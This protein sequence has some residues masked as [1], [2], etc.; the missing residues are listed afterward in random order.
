MNR[1]SSGAQDDQ[2]FKLMAVLAHPDDESLGFARRSTGH[3]R[4]RRL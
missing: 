3:F 4:N 2:K 1:L